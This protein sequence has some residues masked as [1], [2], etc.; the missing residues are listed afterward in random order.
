MPKYI[1]SVEGWVTMQ[2]DT[3][4]EAWE[5]L[6]KAVSADLHSKLAK[7]GSDPNVFVNYIEKDEELN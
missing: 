2:A 3:A 7:L 5:K 4:E 6:D 1:A